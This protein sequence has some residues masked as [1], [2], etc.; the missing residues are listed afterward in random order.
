MLTLEISRR[1]K[2]S[3]KKYKNNKKVLQE[4]ELVVD[5]LIRHKVLPEKYR[6]HE[7]SGNMKSIRECHVRPDTL[8]LYYVVDD[9][10]VLKL[11]EIGSHSDVFG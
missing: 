7:L 9:K 11:Y 5:S 4:L 6:D 3:L 8:L 1:F 2:K 10:G